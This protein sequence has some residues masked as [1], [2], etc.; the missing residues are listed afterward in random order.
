MAPLGRAALRLRCPLVGAKLTRDVIV[1]F[2]V[3]L[4]S[5]FAGGRPSRELRSVFI[6]FLLDPQSR[7]LLEEGNFAELRARDRTLFG[8][9]SK[10]P[11]EER[12]GLIGYLQSQVPLKEFELAT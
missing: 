4:C 1:L 2:A 8:S 6:A 5:T 10:L 12:S 9:L 11:I 7:S 3:A